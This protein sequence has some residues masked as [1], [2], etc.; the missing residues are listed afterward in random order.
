MGRGALPRRRRGGGA[1]REWGR[2]WPGLSSSRRRVRRRGSAGA[3]RDSVTLRP[4]GSRLRRRTP[5]IPLLPAPGPPPAP[6]PRLPAAASSSSS[7]SSASFRR[8]HAGPASR[9]PRRAQPPRGPAARGRGGGGAAAAARACQQA[10]VGREPSLGLAAA[11]R[12]GRKRKCPAAGARCSPVRPLGAVWGRQ[13]APSQAGDLL[14]SGLSAAPPLG[15][16]ERGR[17]VQ[18]RG[19]CDSG[20]S[21]P[22]PRGCQADRRRRAAAT[23]DP[24][25]RP[26]SASGH[27]LVFLF[28]EPTHLPY[29]CPADPKGER[30]L[31]SSL[32]RVLPRRVTR[33]RERA[34]A[35]EAAEV[36]RWAPRPLPREPCPLKTPRWPARVCAAPAQSLFQYL[37]SFFECFENC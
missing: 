4:A 30:Q 13:A 8:P 32:R 11:L 33:G 28:E 29:Y 24:E 37:G 6:L 3:R 23:P 5:Q 21:R 18:T 14:G 35:Q 36:G 15:R 27:V 34:W 7:S 31:A 10:A 26:R 12:V 25:E 19:S 1:G 16:A 9:C 2:A 22:R 17:P 20:G